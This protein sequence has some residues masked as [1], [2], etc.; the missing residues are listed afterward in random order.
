[1]A[2]WQETFDGII[3]KIDAHFESLGWYKNEDNEWETTL[4]LDDPSIYIGEHPLASIMDGTAARVYGVGAKG[5]ANFCAETYVSAFEDD[6]FDIIELSD[7]ENEWF[8]EDEGNWDEVSSYIQ[9]WIR[10]IIDEDCVA[11]WLA[12]IGY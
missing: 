8:E 1:M 10:P 7:E 6:F 2:S 9:G 4:W 3:A 12:E 11:R 5:V